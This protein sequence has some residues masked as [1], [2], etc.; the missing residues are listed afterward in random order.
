MK[1]LV[2]VLVADHANCRVVF[3]LDSCGTLGSRKKRDFA[4]MLAWVDCALESLLPVL[5]L[6]KA[7]ALSFRNDEEVIVCLALLNLYL[8]W[9]AHHELNF[10]YHVVFDV[11]I[12]RKN[13][14][15]LQ[16]LGEDESRNLLLEAGADHFEE[17]SELVL[18]IKRLLNVLQV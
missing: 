18:M 10:G 4:E 5:I 6:D 8:F 2:E 1:H 16:L 17:L 7:F 12:Q 11:R 15:L 13:Q 14:V 9:L 3:R